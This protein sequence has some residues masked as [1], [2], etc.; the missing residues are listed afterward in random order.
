MFDYRT[1]RTRV[2][3]PGAPGSRAERNHLPL[4]LVL[5]LLRN[6]DGVGVQISAYTLHAQHQRE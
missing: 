4:S 6:Q 3:D 5:G 1:E 2:G